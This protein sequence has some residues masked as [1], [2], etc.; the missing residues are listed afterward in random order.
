MLALVLTGVL[1]F[2]NLGALRAFGLSSSGSRVITVNILGDPPTIGAEIEF[3]ITNTSTKSP[4]TIV[5]GS[6][7]PE[8]LVATYRDGTFA[9]S[10]ACNGGGTYLMSV[11]LN[12]GTNV[13]QTLNYDSFNQPGPATAA[14]Y[15]IRIQ[16]PVPVTPT[17]SSTPSDPTVKPIAS[18]PADL[19]PT[20]TPIVVTTPVPQ[21]AENPCYDITRDADLALANPTIMANCINRSI[22]T[23]EKITLPIRVSGGLAPFALSIDWGD[24]ITELKSVADTDYHD[25]EHV[26]QSSGIINVALKTTDSNGSTS[27]LQTVV[28]VNG[29]SAGTATPAGP[30]GTFAT[31]S[32]GLSSIWTQAPIP[33]YWAAVTLVL[34]FWVGDIV[35]RVLA[36][37][38]HGTKQLPKI[39]HH[40]R[41]A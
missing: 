24:G 41:R 37:G 23:G 22:F 4:I 7:Q 15:I 3:P 32:A 18:I 20:P 39:R 25:Y 31:I 14:V 30:S 1:L 29:N 12:V 13:L 34:G 40:P 6:C 36:K 17:S 16:D 28:Q 8:T 5:S 21:P 26:Y 33:L 38:K 11:Q 10:T 35:Q 9:G 2:S 27:F 19:K